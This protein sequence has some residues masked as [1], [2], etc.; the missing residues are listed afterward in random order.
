MGQAVGLKLGGVSVSLNGAAL[1]K[2]FSLEIAPGEVVTLMGPS[3]SGKSSLLSHIAGDLPE[4]MRGGGT[5]SVH[6]F[7]RLFQDD[8]LF[9]HLS[10]RENL[11]FGVPRG[12]RAAREAVANE[13][14]QSAGLEGFGDR[15]PHTLS[16]GQR[17]RVALFRALLAKPEAM[18]LDEPFSKL[19]QALRQSTRDYVF[20]HL[21]ARKIPTLMVTHDRQDAPPGGR[22]LTIRPGGEVT[23]V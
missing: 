14:L 3:G 19:D 5:V 20:G 7:G 23:D 13:A 9:P 17:S 16:G 22:V 6:R 2:P 8:L 21:R 10:V 1:I 4:S 11:L 15:A 18:L 12:D